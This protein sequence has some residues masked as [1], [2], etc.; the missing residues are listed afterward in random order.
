MSAAVIT[1]QKPTLS[2]RM[3]LCN[4]IMYTC[5]QSR[6]QF[7]LP[8]C[9]LHFLTDTCTQMWTDRAWPV[10]ERAA[11][12]PS[13]PLSLP[14]S[15]PPLH[16]PAWS[17]L[18]I[19]FSFSFIFQK[20]LSPPFPRSYNKYLWITPLF[21]CQILPI[22]AP[23][24]KTHRHHLRLTY[25]MKLSSAAANWEFAVEHT[26]CIFVNVCTKSKTLT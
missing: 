24:N 18:F 12:W 4:V 8:L 10:A 21:Y 7:R 16:T 2:H 23:S 20:V 25:A 19:D 3:L 26:I 22:P 9:T 6:S 17:I 15:I 11:A 5:R 13:I 14:P 1:S